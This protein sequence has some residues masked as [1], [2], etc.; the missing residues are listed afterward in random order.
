[1]ALAFLGPFISTIACGELISIVNHGFEDQVVVDGD[2]IRGTLTGWSVAGDSGVFNPLTVSLPE[3]P[4]EGVNV[5]F[6]G[7]TFTGGPISQTLSTVLMTG[8]YKLRIDV[9]DRLD[10]T[11][12][13][14]AIELLAGSAILV[15]DSNTI[16]PSNGTFVTSSTTFT[17]LASDVNLGQPLTIKISAPNNGS[18]FQTLFDNIRLEWNVATSSADFDQDGDV[19]GDDLIQWQ[20]DY[21]LNDESDAD[22]DGDSDGRDFMAWQR[23]FTGPGALSASVSVPEPGTGLLVVSM[24]A[25][26]AA[27]PRG[28]HNGLA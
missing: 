18:G 3:Q 21:G 23:Q 16:T 22:G 20:G 2:F 7:G 28:R 19:D 13:G 1:M 15:Q 17:T 11:F 26:L 8:S 5:A 6:I 10:T 12:A 4:P 14:Y 24:A 27:L 9:G 25:I